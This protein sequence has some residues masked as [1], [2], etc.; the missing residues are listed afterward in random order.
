VLHFPSKKIVS[1]KLYYS[2]VG[3]LVGGWVVGWKGGWMVPHIQFPIL[4][5]NNPP[6]QPPYPTS[7]PTSHATPHLKSHP[8]GLKTPMQVPIELPIECPIQPCILLSNQ[9]SFTIESWSTVFLP[10]AKKYNELFKNYTF[11]LSLPFLFFSSL[12]YFFVNQH[13]VFGS[14]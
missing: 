2:W 14:L 11:S 12:I 6:N 8:I 7:H 3:S 4:P 10:K 5:P 1:N 9:M 13:K